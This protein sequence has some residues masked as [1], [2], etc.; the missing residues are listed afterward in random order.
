M[1]KIIWKLIILTL[2]VLI[3]LTACSKKEENKTEVESIGKNYVKVA[4]VEQK[5]IAEFLLFTGQLE[6][7]Q[8]AYIGSGMSL[9]IKDI[10]VDEGDFVNEGDALVLMDDSQLKQA[11]AQFVATEKNYN[12]IKILKEKGSISNETYDKVEAAYKAAKAGYEFMKSNTEITAPFSGIIT[13][14]LKKA[15]E[16]FTPMMGGAILKLVNIN[17]LKI[18]VCISD[19]DINLVKKDQNAKIYVD[20]YPDEVFR[21]IVNYVSPE[22]DMMSGTFICEILIDNTDA[23]L[24]PRQYA[25][26][27]IITAE[28]KDAVVVPQKAVVND[29]M[30]FIVENDRAIKRTVTL[31]IQNED[32][33]EIVK[34][35][36]PGET[37]VISGNVG[38]K[39]SALVVVK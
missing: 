21:G 15:G 6:A 10:L 2:A 8:E 12:R 37:I 26:V 18:K 23:R 13:T 11:E 35:I 7:V 4:L 28:K 33:I 25:R 30:I 36:L 16:E 9:R 38:L 1:K 3:I 31:G 20:S 34:G 29:N 32:E 5:T 22:A 19:K 24:K 39:D 17:E 27:K 14:K